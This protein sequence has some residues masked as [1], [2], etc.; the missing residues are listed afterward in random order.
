MIDELHLYLVHLQPQQR[1]SVSQTLAKRSIDSETRGLHRLV[2]NPMH[3][4]VRF[5]HPLQS[6]VPQRANT[7]IIC[8]LPAQIARCAAADVCIS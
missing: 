3:S 8:I 4:G 6:R 5:G 7:D 2:S 1:A